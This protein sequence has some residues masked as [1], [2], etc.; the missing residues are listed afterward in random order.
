MPQE[1]L[2]PIEDESLIQGAFQVPKEMSILVNEKCKVHTA[3]R[4]P[5]ASES[6][7]TA[8]WRD[9]NRSR[10]VRDTSTCD[11]VRRNKINR[12]NSRSGMLNN[13]ILLM[14]QLFVL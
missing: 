2:V 9:K 11:D 5:A 8:I 13:V 7:S 6:N 10:G 3:I 1:R 14:F 4:A 12:G